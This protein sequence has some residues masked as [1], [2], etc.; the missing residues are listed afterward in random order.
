M[1]V[2]TNL[3]ETAIIGAG[4]GGLTAAIAL[5][6]M[7]RKVTVFEKAP[8]LKAMG[9]G[10]VLAANAMKALEK[11]SVAEQVRQ[12]GAPVK[13]A[14]IRT[15][16][17]KLLVNMPVH[18]QANRYGTYSYLIY[19]PDLQRILYEKLKPDT[20]LL[21]KKFIR[22]NQIRENI[23]CI[24]EDG[25]SVNS[26]LVIGADGVHSLVRKSLV[27]S[28]P[29]RYS[30]FT[31]FRGIS[32]FDDDMFPVEQGGG[33]EAWG[34]GKRFGFSHLGNGRIFWFAAINTPQGTLV[35]TDDRKMMA[36]QQFRGWWKPIESVIDSTQ[37]S[38]ILVH[39]IFD[40]EP[41]KRWSK[42]KVTLLGDAAHPMLPNL[43]QG[44]AQAMEDAIVL[45]S[46]LGQFP[47][48]IEKALL[49]YEQL[50][51][52]RTTQVVQ[53]SRLMARMMQFESPAAMKM[54]NMM[55][56]SIPDALKIRQLNW[57]VGYEV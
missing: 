45:A 35:K 9:A 8:E 21:N 56:R 1:D 7:G 11:L 3:S 2:T 18:K 53:G 26:H 44:G 30:G 54:R 17:G 40:R 47:E 10:I 57:I 51:V 16:D 48:G 55:M 52:S 5:Q 43:G 36:L 4:I 23:T 15:W 20:V 29:L 22:L 41:I 24:F 14:E 6:Q 32:Y 13:K 42:G 46:C 25:E 34:Y 50:R 39:E 31:A 12:A 33:F 28:S 19:R 49:K 27:E 37:E 38:N